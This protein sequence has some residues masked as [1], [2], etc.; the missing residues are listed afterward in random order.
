MAKECPNVYLELT[1]VY[2]GHD[3]TINPSS[4][5]FIPASWLQVNGII[6]HMVKRVSAEKN[7]VWNGYALV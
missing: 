7:L 4:A 3:F 1:A 5:G 6:E 2:V